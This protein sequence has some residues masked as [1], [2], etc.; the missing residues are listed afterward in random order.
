MPRWNN[1]N[2][3]FQKGHKKFWKKH[4]MLGKQH[5]KETKLKM[6][7]IKK[8]KIP[9][10]MTAKIKEK[11]SISKMGNKNP[12]WKGGIAFYSNIHKWLN[13]TFGKADK[14]ENINC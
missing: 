12:Q 2:C 1:L 5:T 13:L 9:Y 14:C 11:L 3:G 10:K 8:G 6:S 4:P 7:L